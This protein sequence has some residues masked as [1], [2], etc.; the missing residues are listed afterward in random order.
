VHWRVTL[1]AFAGQGIDLTDVDRIGIGRGREAGLTAPG[2][3]GTIFIDD[4]ALYRPAH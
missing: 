2:G 1:Q 4:I 3:T